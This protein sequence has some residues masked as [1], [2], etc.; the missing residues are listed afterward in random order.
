MRKKKEGEEK[1]KKQ[2]WHESEEK[3]ITRQSETDKEKEKK[4]TVCV[5]MNWFANSIFGGGRLLFY[6]VFWLCGFVW[7]G[8]WCSCLTC[9]FGCWLC[10]L[11]T[12]GVYGGFS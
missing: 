10:V 12:L 9:V 2:D 4:Q 1:K 11:K 6:F 7:F 3:K 5:S 8:W